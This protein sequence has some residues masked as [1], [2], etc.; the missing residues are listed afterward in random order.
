[1]Q[2][3]FLS[4]SST[5]IAILP[6][7]ASQRLPRT[8]QR[9]KPGNRA[10]L[11]S[12][13]RKSAG[14]SEMLSKRQ[15]IRQRRKLERAGSR[16]GSGR[17]KLRSG[18]ARSFGTSAEMNSSRSR[19][20][21]EK[22]AM[23]ALTWRRRKISPDYLSASRLL[24]MMGFT[25][26]FAYLMGLDPDLATPRLTTPR[27]HV[28]AGS[29]GIADQQTGIYPL[30]SPGGWQIIGK[31]ERLLFNPNQVPYFLFSPGDQVRFIPAN[32]G[33]V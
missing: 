30:D 20:F 24:A 16:L 11:A 2:Q 29:V 1:M 8:G 5:L 33:L 3:G 12:M 32:G 19:R 6:T 18:L 4:K 9:R 13:S 10:I 28:S 22:A 21:G 23:A 26:G 31:T 7:F 14:K 25:P 27:T 15:K 17:S